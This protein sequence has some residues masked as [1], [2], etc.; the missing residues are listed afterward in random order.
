MPDGEPKSN[1]SELPPSRSHA[2]TIIVHL[3]PSRPCLVRASLPWLAPAARRRPRDALRHAKVTA[4]RS[5]SC[6]P[7]RQT[8]PSQARRG[9]PRLRASSV[10]GVLRRALSPRC[11]AS[12]TA[13]RRPPLPWTWTS[14]SVDSTYARGDDLPAAGASALRGASTHIAPALRKVSDDYTAARAPACFSSGWHAL[15]AR[16]GFFGRT[17]H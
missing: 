16:R 15:G 5:S 9:M 13:R 1:K 10:R 6:A 8:R 4:C 3:E 17:V 7:R 12:G 14:V 11:S 2:P